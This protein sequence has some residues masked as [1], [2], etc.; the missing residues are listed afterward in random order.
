MENFQLYRTNIALGGQMKWDLIV[1]SGPKGLYV[2]DFHLTPISRAVPYNRYS[3]DTLINYSHLENVKNYYKQVEGSFYSECADP[4]VT[5]KNATMVDVNRPKSQN[6]DTHNSTCEMGLKRSQYSIYHKQFEYFCP[7]WLE[8]LVGKYLRFDFSSYTIRNGHRSATVTKSLS[9][10][11]ADE[12]LA[13]HNSFVKYFNQYVRDISL[14]DSVAKVDLSGTDSYIS[15]VDVKTGL[16]TLKRIPTLAH[17]LLR[18]ERLLMDADSLL[19]QPFQNNHIVAKQLFNFNFVFDMGE[20][21][22]RTA[23]NSILGQSFMFN[24]SVNLVDDNGNIEQ[25]SKK[26]FYTNYDYIASK[27]VGDISED[28]ADISIFDELM[29]NYSVDLIDKNKTTQPTIHWSLVGNNDYIF[30]VYPGFGGYILTG[31]DKHPVQLNTVYQN[32]PNIWVEEYSS[33]LNNIGW[34][35]Y[36]V[37]H[38]SAQ[39]LSELR[40]IQL[41]P[42]HR[43]K[44]MT[45][46]GGVWSTSLQYEPSDTRLPKLLIITAPD[47]AL[48]KIQK[49]LDNLG[50]IASGKDWAWVTNLG[51]GMAAIICFNSYRNAITFSNIRNAKFS[52]GGLSVDDDDPTWG[53]VNKMITWLN[54]VKEPKIYGFDT[55]LGY[56]IADGPTNPVIEVQHYK[57]PGNKSIIRYDGLIKPTFVDPDLNLVWWKCLLDKNNHPIPPEFADP[58]S[59]MLSYNRSGYAANYPSL[60]YYPWYATPIVIEDGVVK[61]PDEKILDTLPYEYSW[62][63]NSI[64]MLLN[65]ELSFTLTP[66]PEQA[67]TNDSIKKLIIYSI[68]TYY[69]VDFDKAVYIFN[70]YD[71]KWGWEYT[72]KDNIEKYTYYVKLTLK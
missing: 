18:Q 52:V 20:I 2:S 50:V 60:Q 61:Q 71:C 33:E 28:A 41:D 69:S 55:C 3:Q 56:V 22:N 30:N 58:A 65:N 15:G 36:Y 68:V 31:E 25:L 45:N 32:S 14:D 4:R 11:L 21:L 12:V 10:T 51:D 37:A 13:Y 34:C 57:V 46:I 44:V 43:N 26:D 27:H 1:E 40:R 70:Q 66:D 64:Y 35:N 38:D 29:D 54:T 59:N 67:C 7:L 24:I 17:N 16:L 62:Y 8:D 53:W 9:F 19:I 5:S 39:V 47:S 48:Q 23:L 72:E 63:D 6:F 42:E 49:S